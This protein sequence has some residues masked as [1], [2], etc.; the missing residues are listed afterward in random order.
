MWDWPL[1]R[2]EQIDVSQVMDAD[3]LSGVVKSRLG[4]GPAA[5][6][7]QPVPHSMQKA[8]QPPH[9]AQPLWLLTKNQIVDYSVREG[10]VVDE[11]QE[12]WLRQTGGGDQMGDA[13]LRKHTEPSIRTHRR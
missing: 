10:V 9:R 3:E 2:A 11:P 13:K 5:Q 6:R 1:L 12:V 8:A 7:E 4:R